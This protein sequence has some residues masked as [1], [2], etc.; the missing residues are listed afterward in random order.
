[1]VERRERGRAQGGLFDGNVP[2]VCLAAVFRIIYAINDTPKLPLS[3]W[4]PDATVLAESRLGCSLDRD[5]GKEYLANKSPAVASILTSPVAAGELP[6]WDG[7][8]VLE[9]LFGDAADAC[10]TCVERSPSA[11]L[12]PQAHRIPLFSFVLG[13]AC[14][15]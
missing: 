1:M 14:N 10:T 6:V 11:D 13:G 7:V 5:K 3:R 9:I 4:I 8:P 12:P 2:G 15:Q